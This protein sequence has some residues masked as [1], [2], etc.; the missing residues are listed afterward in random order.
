MVW[1]RA[2]E[3]SYPGNRTRLKAEVT[4]HLPSILPPLFVL[5][6]RDCIPQAPAAH[7]ENHISASLQLGAPHAV[8]QTLLGGIAC[9]ALEQ[10]A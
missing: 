8:S 2:G 5:A 9:K 10:W 3:A 1:G 4:G 7:M 6:N